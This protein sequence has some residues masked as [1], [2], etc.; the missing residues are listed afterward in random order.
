M[1][2][3]SQTKY[4]NNVQYDVNIDFEQA[5]NEWKL[6][7]KYIGNGSYKYIC[8]KIGK[9]NKHCMFKCVSCEN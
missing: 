5:S 6:N 3:R 8:C 7:K 4:E 2:T 1:K 9:N